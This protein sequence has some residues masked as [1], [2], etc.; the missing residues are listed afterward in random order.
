MFFLVFPGLRIPEGS[1][2]CTMQ[3]QNNAGQYD[4][5]PAAPVASAK[6]LNAMDGDRQHQRQTVG[7]GQSQQQWLPLICFKC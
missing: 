6:D 4:S 7:Q 3:P 1:S 5:K 2:A